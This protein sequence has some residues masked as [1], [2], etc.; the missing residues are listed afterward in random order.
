MGTPV[1]HRRDRLRVGAGGALPDGDGGETW[2]LVATGAI[3]WVSFLGRDQ[4]WLGVSE[5]GVC[6]TQGCAGWIE[7][8]SDGGAT[9]RGVAKDAGGGFAGGPSAPASLPWAEYGGGGYLGQGS[10]YVYTTVP[11]AQ[12][13]RTSD[14]GRNWHGTLPNGSAPE[15]SVSVLP[16]GVG[17]ALLYPL[18]GST[19]P[20]GVFSTRDGGEQWQ[21]AGATAQMYSWA[22]TAA[23][24]SLWLMSGSAWGQYATARP[25]QDPTGQGRLPPGRRFAALDAS[26]HDRAWAVVRGPGGGSIWATADGGVH[27][28]QVLAPPE[29]PLPSGNF[30]FWSA[31]QGYSA[32]GA[33]LRTDDGGRTWRQVGAVGAALHLTQIGFASGEV[34]WGID[35]DGLPWL[36]L[37]GGRDWRRIPLPTDVALPWEQVARIGFSDARHGYMLV[38]GSE[39]NELSLYVTRDGGRTWRLSFQGVQ[40]VG[41]ADAADGWMLAGSE[42]YRTADGGRSWRAVL[43]HVPANYAMFGDIA[44]VPGKPQALWLSDAI[45]GDLAVT[46]NGGR[47]FIV[48][49]LPAQVAQTAGAPTPSGPKTGL[50]E[51]AGGLWRTTDAGRNW[52]LVGRLSG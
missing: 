13:L 3:G 2:R 14:G 24:G 37:N 26:S 25:W 30:G 11:V 6:A 44:A 50:I 51:M 49:R 23:D 5:P 7:A 19:G 16:D 8:T 35:A 34:G 1:S 42:L 48:S 21:R 31:R 22:V 40:A 27:W 28:R 12:F 32:S 45:D 18:M 15:I 20:G 4:G 41:F 29:R 47:S 43:T 10:G 36:S 46:V 38:S 33:I 17:W 52:R 39:P 9:W